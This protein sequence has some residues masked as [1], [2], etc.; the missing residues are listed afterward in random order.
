MKL[1]LSM[2]DAELVG[3]G[4][5]WRRRCS[6]T[7]LDGDATEFRLLEERDLSYVLDVKATTSAITESTVPERP[8]YGGRARPPKARY[9]RLFSTLAA[10]PPRPARL[11]SRS[12]GAKGPAAR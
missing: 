4:L 10:L 2:I 8:E 12:R 3:W 5:R 11:A 9:W 6:A 7:A 1:A